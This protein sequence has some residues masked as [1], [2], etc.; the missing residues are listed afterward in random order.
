MTVSS[1]VNRAGPYLGNGST[2]VFG[3]G[4][5]ILDASHL[6]VIITDANGVETELT[7]PGGYSVSGV[8]AAGG[9]SITRTPAPISGHTVTILRKMP[10]VQETDLENQGAYFAETIERA[11]DE[12]A[13]RD[14]QLAEELKRAVK[15]PAGDDDVE[16][17]LSSSLARGILRIYD[18]ADN[19]DQVA[20]SIGSV[21]TVA[22]LDDEIATVAGNLPAI[23]AAAGSVVSMIP[24]E[25]VGDGTATEF[26]LPLQVAAANALVWVDGDRQRPVLDYGVSFS[27]LIFED[28]PVDGAEI[29]GVLISAVSSQSIQALYDDFLGGVTIVK[30]NLITAAGQRRYPLDAAG[31]PFNLRSA[32]CVVFGASPFGMLTPGVDY[33]ID[34]GVP[35]LSFDPADGE[36]FHVVSMPRVSNSEAQAILQDLEDAIRADADRAEAAAVAVSVFTEEVDLGVDYANPLADPAPFAPVTAEY[37]VGTEMLSGF[38][39][40]HDIVRAG[41]SIAPDSWSEAIRQQF[42]DF[43]KFYPPYAAPGRSTPIFSYLDIGTGT[44]LT[45]GIADGSTVG[46]TYVTVV[47]NY[48]LRKP[49]DVYNLDVFGQNAMAFTP[50]ADRCTAVG[51]DAGAQ[52]GVPSLQYMRDHDHD[53]TRT[54]DPSDPAWNWE[55]VETLHPGMRLRILNYTNWPTQKEDIQ[56][57][58]LLGQNAGNVLTRGS[59]NSLFG[60]AAGGIMWEGSDNT[61]AGYNAGRIA[62]YVNHSIAIGPNAAAK[63]F[64]TTSA[65]AIGSSAMGNTIT[66]NDTVGIGRFVMQNCLTAF[67]SAAVGHNAMNAN[68]TFDYCAGIGFEALRND[69]TGTSLTGT[70]TNSTG[71]GSR[72]RV[73]GSN[74]V[75]LGDNATT[76]YAYA[77][78]QVRSDERDKA[79]IEPTALGLDFIER[80]QPVQYRWDMRDDYVDD[81]PEDQRAEWWSNPVKD[82]SKKRKRMQQGVIAQQVRDV[83]QDMGV[84][85]S[86]LQDHAINGGNDVLT[87]GYEHFVPP[88]IKAIQEVSE[89]L[90]AAEKQITS[91][92]GAVQK[93]SARVEELE[94]DRN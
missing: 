77:A 94:K 56:Y 37:T 7:Y 78:L 26:A 89:R 33:M 42:A 17:D 63:L 34:A 52:M 30:Q 13:M 48:A 22:G 47:G 64:D 28:P 84:D 40:E 21:N 65:I 76:P 88:V 50:R 32:T 75:Q 27:T 25:F 36:L 14:Q 15:V 58:V 45:K 55:G 71:V 18:S 19:L 5:R 83:C 90:K 2:T 46:A 12:A 1:E 10:F 44:G 51:R 9:G 35:L 82:G 53:V 86:G 38:G 39:V 57:N 60:H 54:V 79:D 24:F 85:F 11:F 8:G 61:F 62:Q 72:S 41:L 87:V 80:I 68:A 69:L 16:G 20:G 91:L 74:Q 66:A 81:I 3:F 59:R 6:R 93:M 4:F 73:S 49:I 92:L 23:T 29:S 43:S 70:M 67:R 31:Q